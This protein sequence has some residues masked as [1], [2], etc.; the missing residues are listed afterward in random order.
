[1]TVYKPY[2][3]NIS[4]DQ[5]RQLA[6]GGRIKLNQNHM[7]G[8]GCKCHLTERQALKL[9]KSVMKKRGT[10]LRFSRAQLLHNKIHGGDISGPPGGPPLLADHHHQQPQQQS[11]PG[12]FNRIKNEV[13]RRVDLVRQGPRETETAR[14]KKFIEKEGGQ[15]IKNI[16]VNREPVVSGVKK[17]VNL[18]TFGGLEKARK[19]LGYDDVYHNY[20]IVETDD[21]KKFRV[22]KNHVVEA[23][24][25]KQTGQHKIPLN[26]ATKLGELIKN[27]EGGHPKEFYQYNPV[28]QNCQNFTDDIVKRNDLLKNVDDKTKKILEP[29]DA[30]NLLKGPLSALP[31]VITDLAGSFDRGIHGDGIKRKLKGKGIVTDIK[32][33]ILPIIKTYGQGAALKIFE[34]LIGT[35]TGLTMSQHNELNNWFHGKGIKKNKRRI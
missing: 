5:M 10:S 20:M 33:K 28:G 3:L 19:K 23:K 12:I 14:F 32:R 6:K 4:R 8:G 25:T 24:E 15:N 17:A 16:Y 2:N 35:V 13:K 21:G 27:A 1:M 22:E 29:Q 9:R 31:K 11:K 30:H 26:K 18:L 34:H 7:S